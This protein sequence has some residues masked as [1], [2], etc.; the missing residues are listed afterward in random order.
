MIKKIENE[1]KSQK[2]TIEKQKDEIKSQKE[3]IQ[4]LKKTIG[5]QNENE[6]NKETIDKLNNIEKSILNLRYDILFNTCLT[7]DIKKEIEKNG[8]GGE[9]K[10]KL[11]NDE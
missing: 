3:E 4:S 6:E 7:K 8:M 10:S 5:R 2:E 11:L 1:I 9:E